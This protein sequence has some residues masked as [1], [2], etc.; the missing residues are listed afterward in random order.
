MGEWGG[1]LQSKTGSSRAPTGRARLDDGLDDGPVANAALEADLW[2][3]IESVVKGSIARRG[4]G[5]SRNLPPPP[6][7]MVG[8]GLASG[9]KVHKEQEDS[10]GSSASSSC[11]D[12]S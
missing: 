10:G 2:L 1:R 4:G 7:A 6:A 9:V 12:N 11:P 5:A 8:G 3:S